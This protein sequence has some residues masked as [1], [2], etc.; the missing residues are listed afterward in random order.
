MCPSCPHL[1]QAAVPARQTPLCG[2]LHF[3]QT[4]LS[5]PELEPLPSPRLDLT[6]FQNLFFLGFLVVLLHFL[7]PEAA[8]LKEEEPGVLEPEGCATDCLTVP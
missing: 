6:L 3:A 8:A 4:A 7:L 5:A 2:L 1:K